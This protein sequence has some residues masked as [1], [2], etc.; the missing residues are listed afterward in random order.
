MEQCK[1]VKYENPNDFLDDIGDFVDARHFGHYLFIR[2]ID[3]ILSQKEEIH[4]AYTVKRSD[5]IEIIYMWT[6]HGQYIFGEH[7][8]IESIRLII[9]VIDFSIAKRTGLF[10]SK[11]IIDDIINASKEKFTLVKHRLYFACNQPKCPEI[12][13][14]GQLISATNRELNEI[15]NMALDFYR[16]EFEKGQQTKDEIIGGIIAGINTNHLF[17][18]RFKDK[19]VSYILIIDDRNDKIMIGSIFTKLKFRNKDYGKSMVYEVIRNLFKNENTEFGIMV[20]PDNH[21]SI[22]M[23]SALGFYKSYETAIYECS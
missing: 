23:F 5:Q 10:G 13:A 12:L 7:N 1:L 8:G 3:R 6:N 19:I 16:E 20:N 14:E 17:Y 9:D 15:S 22:K 4:S 21:A 18:W 2:A 11:S